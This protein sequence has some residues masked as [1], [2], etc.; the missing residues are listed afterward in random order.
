[1]HRRAPA[2]HARVARYTCLSRAVRRSACDSEA[3]PFSGLSR[4]WAGVAVP[5]AEP[6]LPNPP[7]G[8]CR[9]GSV[10][11]W[12]ACRSRCDASTSRRSDRISWRRSRHPTDFSRASLAQ[13]HR[14]AWPDTHGLAC[15]HGPTASAA[16]EA[17]ARL[18]SSRWRCTRCA[19]ASS[20]GRQKRSSIKALMLERECECVGALE[21]LKWRRAAAWVGGGNGRV[22]NESCECAYPPGP[23]PS[24]CPLAR[25][26]RCLPACPVGHSGD[27]LSVALAALGPEPDAAIGFLRMD[28]QSRRRRW[29]SMT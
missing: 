1:M 22:A 18:A 20:A 5:S 25:P 21:P 7:T 13:R 23:T 17:R 6:A 14:I 29:G 24:E 15:P 4:A 28:A 27:R 9:G 12:R 10:G 11:V 3:T 16:C 19:C 2:M 26:A 8:P